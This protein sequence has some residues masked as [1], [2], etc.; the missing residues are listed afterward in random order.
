MDEPKFSREKII[1]ELNAKGVN[2]PCHRC[3]NTTFALIDGFS[4]LELLEKINQVKVGGQGIPVFITACS[5]CGAITPHAYYALFPKE[6]EVK[7]GTDER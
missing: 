6:D 1:E 2:H 3:G 4:R 5:M 7:G